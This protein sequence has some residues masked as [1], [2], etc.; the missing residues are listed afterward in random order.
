[1][2][3]YPII[4][5][6]LAGHV[7]RGLYMRRQAEQDDAA[8]MRWEL[9]QAR[10]AEE[11][12]AR[13]SLYRDRFAQDQAEFEYRRQKDAA[14]QAAAAGEDQASMRMATDLGVIGEGGFSPDSFAAA[15]RSVQSTI[16]A[17]AYRRQATSAIAK[18]Q[19][20]AGV[21][22]MRR[23]WT[24]LGRGTTPP[25][26]AEQIMRSELGKLSERARGQ[27]LSEVLSARGTGTTVAAPQPS[28]GGVPVDMEGMTGAAPTIREGAD[29]LGG[30][31]DEVFLGDDEYKALMETQQQETR[32]RQSAEDLAGVGVG[33]DPERATRAVRLRQAGIPIGV[34]DANLSGRQVASK[35]QDD[36]EYQ[37][38]EARVKT[39]KELFDASGLSIAEKKAASESLAAALKDRD[40]YF[41]KRA[42][43]STGSPEAQ[44]ALRAF[45]ERYGREPTKADR[46][47]LLKLREELLK[48]QAA[49]ASRP[50]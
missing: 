4:D 32:L 3:R 43:R 28:V 12:D 39:E 38:L 13:Q 25:P 6:G 9:D 34:G 29:P 5:T 46:Q 16:L 22:R 44:G 33:Y 26:I 37:Y 17:D 30:V 15:P 14:A 24:A 27:F 2:S 48:L 40:A 21:Q 31:P 23:V 41:A 18:Q 8:Q 1:M 36:P 49:G 11:E 42:G 10:R 19:D 7:S 35:Y 20:D 47:E 45:R 50:Q